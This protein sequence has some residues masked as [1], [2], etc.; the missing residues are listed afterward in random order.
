MLTEFCD[1][2]GLVSFTRH[3]RNHVDYSYSFRPNDVQFNV[4]DFF[5]LS[6]ALFEKAIMPID[7][8]HDG[9]NRSDHEPVIMKMCLD[10]NYFSLSGKVYFYK[11]AWYKDD[12][13]HIWLTTNAL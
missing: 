7:V 4:F 3:T 8:M 12:G 11:I 5:I 10:S 1:N 13:N 9:D 6:G 2:S